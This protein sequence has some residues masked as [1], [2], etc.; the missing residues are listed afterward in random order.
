MNLD[1]CRLHRKKARF[2]NSETQTKIAREC[3]RE[4]LLPRAVSFRQDAEPDTEEA[5]AGLLS[6]EAVRPE[7]DDLNRNEPLSADG[8]PELDRDTEQEQQQ[9]AE[10]QEAEMAQPEETRYPDGKETMSKASRQQSDS[11]GYH[12]CIKQKDDLIGSC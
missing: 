12:V 2:N 4:P 5:T 11:A 6:H 9:F 8:E 3:K 7:D 1:S 10:R